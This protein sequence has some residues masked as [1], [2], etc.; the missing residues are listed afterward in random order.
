MIPETSEKITTDTAESRGEQTIAL[1][2]WLTREYPKTFNLDAPVPL[3]IGIHLDLA[4]QHPDLDPAT[5][6]R[7]LIRYCARRAYQIALAREGACRVD[8]DGQPAGEVTAEQATI[9]KAKLTAWKAKKPAKSAA[10]ST[11]APTP[12]PTP[13][14]PPEQPEPPPAAVPGR[15]VLRL[16]KPAG[17]VV[18]AAIARR[19]KS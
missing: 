18:S 10:P 7:A 9:A 3:K 1:Q 19:A 13:P 14:P 6:R 11:P 4:A 2:S 12:A 15:P 17:T 8:L 16:K 5:L